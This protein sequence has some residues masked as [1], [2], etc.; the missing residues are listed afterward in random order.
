[1]FCYSIKF[2]NHIKI[3]TKHQFLKKKLG[4]NDQTDFMVTITSILQTE[5]YYNESQFRG[6]PKGWSNKTL[7]VSR[8]LSFIVE[9]H[10]IIALWSSANGTKKY[11]VIKCVCEN[12]L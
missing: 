11:Y 8:L 1:M 10:H 2:I 3:R 5:L 12:K 9:N 6:H 7:S 4:S